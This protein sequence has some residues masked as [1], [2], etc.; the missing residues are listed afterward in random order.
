MNASSHCHSTRLTPILVLGGGRIS[1]AECQMALALGVRTAV[2]DIENSAV[3][4]AIATYGWTDHPKLHSQ[5]TDPNSLRA[6]V[7]AETL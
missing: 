6:F 4:K 2:I 5:I 3:A 1:A 7:K